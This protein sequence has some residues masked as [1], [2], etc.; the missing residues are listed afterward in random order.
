MRSYWS[1]G[2]KE[3]GRGG[4]KSISGTGIACAK[5]LKW[6]GPTS[7]MAGCSELWDTVFRIP[8]GSRSNGS[9]DEFKVEL[10]LSGNTGHLSCWRKIRGHDAKWNRGKKGRGC[11]TDQKQ[12]VDWL[13]M[14][15]DKKKGKHQVH[16]AFF[17]R[18]SGVA[19]PLTEAENVGA[20]KKKV[21][22]DDQGF[23]MLARCPS[24]AVLW[25]AEY[26]SR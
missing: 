10:S 22:R 25:A 18:V 2:C 16:L 20:T 21:W 15:R 26:G 3:G 12:D 8:N 4:E 23:H 7:Y 19:L 13:N 11:S 1:K 9:Y 17:M 14:E 6:E 24:G 5:G